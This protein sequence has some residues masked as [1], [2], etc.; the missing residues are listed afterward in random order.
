MPDSSLMGHTISLPSLLQLA[1]MLA[2]MR[3]CTSLAGPA[4]W[5]HCCRLELEVQEE[6]SLVAVMEKAVVP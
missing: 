2:A 1:P 4:S 6:E 5:R 3:Q